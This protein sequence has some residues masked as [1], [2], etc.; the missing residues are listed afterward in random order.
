MASGAPD[1]RPK[2][3]AKLAPAL[4]VPS[5][6]EEQFRKEYGV[7]RVG[8]ATGVKAEFYAISVERKIKH[9]AVAAI[10]AAAR[11]DIFA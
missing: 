5:I 10:C 11:Q 4:T 1:A 8:V 6:L 2:E 9:P 7:A 3:T